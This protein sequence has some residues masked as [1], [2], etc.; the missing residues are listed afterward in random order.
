[1]RSTC[2][3][4]LL[5]VQAFGLVHVVSARHAWADGAVVDVAK[6][7]PHQGAH[8]CADAVDTQ[9]DECPVL[10]QW[11]AGATLASHPRLFAVAPQWP[12]DHRG[13]RAARST[14]AVLH[15]APKASPPEQRSFTHR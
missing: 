2:A 6:V 9:A 4:V 15:V 14:L 1:M 10:A 3:A 13:L 5:L 7:D 8:V 12:V 11:Q